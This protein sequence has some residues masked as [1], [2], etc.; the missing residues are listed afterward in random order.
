MEGGLLQIALQPVQRQHRKVF[1]QIEV[2][3]L[4]RK[5]HQPRNGNVFQ[6][7]FPQVMG[8]AVGVG[9]VL[10]QGIVELVFPLADF[11]QPVLALG[12]AVDHPGNVFGFNGQ[13]PKIADEQVVDLGGFVVKG[14]VNVVF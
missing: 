3:I 7:R 2:D 10:Q 14:Q 1:R 11:L 4:G 13:H 8:Q 12:I 9:L 5:E 6:S